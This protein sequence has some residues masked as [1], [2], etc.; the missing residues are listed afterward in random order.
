LAPLLEL[1]KP[2]ADFSLENLILVENKLITN[3]QQQAKPRDVVRHI[4]TE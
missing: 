3:P 4:T 1:F 2:D